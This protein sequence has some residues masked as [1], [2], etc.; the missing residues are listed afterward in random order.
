M[1]SAISHLPVNTKPYRS[2]FS[3]KDF[4]IDKFRC[5]RNHLRHLNTDMYIRFVR[6]AR[7]V[8]K[9]GNVG[10]M[11]NGMNN[12]RKNAISSLVWSEIIVYISTNEKGI[13][14]FPFASE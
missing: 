9:P 7:H 11:N 10:V 14:L 5:L 2:L 6:T 13:S 4:L 3:V 8:L 1:L 12:V